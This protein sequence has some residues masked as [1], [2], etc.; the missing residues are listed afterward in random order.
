M[1]MT[2]GD[3]PT[4]LT[5]YVREGV[6]APATPRR[7]RV[8][9]FD[10]DSMWRVRDGYNALADG[11]HGV[12]V[13]TIDAVVLGLVYVLVLPFAG[14]LTLFAVP[15]WFAGKAVVIG[16]M[17]TDQHWTAVGPMPGPV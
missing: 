2:F 7:D 12:W 14:T 4:L 13:G 16:R 1:V 11:D 5:R 8:V 6:A 10:E 9:T 17:E 3:A 15:F